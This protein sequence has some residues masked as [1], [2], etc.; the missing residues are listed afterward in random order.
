MWVKHTKMPDVYEVHPSAPSAAKA[1]KPE[2][3][4]VPD[5][6]SSLMLRRTFEYFGVND[7]VPMECVYNARFKKWAPVG[8]V[9]ASS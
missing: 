6:A 1:N 7:A 3:A 5:L 9:V 2:I 4:C 8:A